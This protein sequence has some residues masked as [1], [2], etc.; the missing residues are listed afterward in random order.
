MAIKKTG[1]FAPGEIVYARWQGDKTFIVTRE[2]QGPVFTHYVC[3]LSSLYAVEDYWLFPLIHLSREPITK[4][5]GSHNRK[6]LSLFTNGNI[7]DS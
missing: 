7:S 1:G 5:T 3:K 6:Q 2:F 4:I